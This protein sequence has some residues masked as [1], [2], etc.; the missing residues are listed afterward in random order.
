MRRVWHQ[1]QAAAL[2]QRAQDRL[3][4]RGLDTRLARSDVVAVSDDLAK[5]LN[6][7]P[8]RGDVATLLDLVR[9]QQD[10]IRVNELMGEQAET[11]RDLLVDLNRSIPVVVV[12]HD[13]TSLASMV[14]RI[15]CI[16]RKLFYHGDP[17]LSLEVMEEVYG[18]P[19]EL[20]THGVPHR[21]L[22]HHHH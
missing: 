21:V 6:H 22:H 20:V 7:Q 5:A 10:R 12:T 18:C 15:A 13:V 14:R 2:Y 11:L 1:G 4:L 3:V 8:E 19:V 9:E 17:E 16:N